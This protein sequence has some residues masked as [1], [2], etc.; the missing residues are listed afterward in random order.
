MD[1]EERWVRYC[2]TMECK[3]CGNPIF[4]DEDAAREEV[5]TIIAA[6]EFDEGTSID[7]LRDAL[8]WSEH[9][10]R[11]CSWCTHMINKDC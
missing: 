8:S 11:Y 9:Q 10:G 6:D 4:D 7:A 1:L 2:L 5:E 3:R